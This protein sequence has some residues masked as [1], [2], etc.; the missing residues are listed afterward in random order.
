[1]KEK[2]FIGR[3]SFKLKFSD[4]TE[5]VV[6]SII[7]SKISDAQS[8][9]V[10]TIEFS[11]FDFF[12]H[13]DS[14]E[15]LSQVVSGKKALQKDR[16]SEYLV[17]MLNFMYKT[18]FN[19][20]EKEV[21]LIHFYNEYLERRLY[22]LKNGD[23][24]GLIPSIEDYKVDK[25]YE[26]DKYIISIIPEKYIKIHSKNI[27]KDIS[28]REELFHTFQNKV[29]ELGAGVSY[30]KQMEFANEYFKERQERTGE[31]S[32]EFNLKEIKYRHLLSTIEENGERFTLPQALTTGASERINIPFFMESIGLLDVNKL[33]ISSLPLQIEDI[34]ILYSI[35]KPSV[36]NKYSAKSFGLDANKRRILNESQIEIFERFYTK[37]FENACF[38][39]RP[40]LEQQF[41][42]IFHWLIRKVSIC[43]EEPSF[44]KE[45][46]SKWLDENDSKK[47]VQMEDDF[48][49]PF[50]HERLKDEFGDLISKKPEKFGGE[51]DLLYDE[52]PI[53]LKVRK[54]ISESLTDVIDEKYK[55][56]SQAATYAAITRLG[57]VVVLDLPQNVN[58]IT[59]LDVCFRLIEKDFDGESLKT[60]IVVCIFYCNL[61]TPSQAK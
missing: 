53:E 8:T 59:N 45:K 14:L 23:S 44:L 6:G 35:N 27:L 12:P 46:S 13:H 1:M 32:F 52:L 58:S 55:P 36:K 38:I 43:L 47:Y 22:Y 5:L 28:L 61:P 11:L 37:L 18:D 3:A 60:N 20:N 7:V 30:R 10:E 33:K 41:S 2:G 51:V 9:N 54:N 57:F 48:F 15:N 31:K 17:D 39:G 49:L 40:K 42:E 24:V 56:A 50:L 34:E 19:S 4:I 26:L 25:T 16:N 29:E 21:D